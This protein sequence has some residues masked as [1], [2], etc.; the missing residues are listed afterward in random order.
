VSERVSE[1][2]GTSAGRE[3]DN[4]GVKSGLSRGLADADRIGIVGFSRSCY[5]V[6]EA[7]TAGS[8]RFRTAS[9]TD[10]VNAGYMLYLTAVDLF[11]DIGRRD[12]EA[13]IG[14]MPFGAVSA[15]LQVTTLG[16]A[17]LTLMWEP[18]AL[19]RRL[20]K[21]VDLIVLNNNEHVLTNP[22]ARLMSQGGSVDWMRFWLQGYE[23]SAKDKV[24]QYQRWEKLCDLQREQNADRPTFCVSSKVH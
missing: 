12:E 6:L 13:A 11:G 5:Y 10:G 21:P 23:D 17:N 7:L 16:R 2:N 15:A 19:M 24:D 22:L 4:G 8:L 14:A 1:A 9:I 3:S 20:N 18:Y